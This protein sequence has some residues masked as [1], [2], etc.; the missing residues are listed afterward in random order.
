MAVDG[1]D[2]LPFATGS[3]RCQK[4]ICKPATF[5]A[6]LAAARLLGAV[7]LARACATGKAR[8]RR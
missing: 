5:R 6:G 4:Q 2:R 7:H 1:N 8:R 3:G